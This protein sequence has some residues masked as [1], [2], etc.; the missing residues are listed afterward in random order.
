M[1]NTLQRI[2]NQKGFTLVELMIVV[3][4][5]GILAAIAIPAF[6]RSVKK[7]KTSEAEGTMRKVADGSK[8]YFQG[9]QKWSRPQTE[10]GE[11]PWHAGNPMQGTPTT[12]GLP[13]PWN[14]YTFP[15]GPAF[16]FN[17]AD[18]AADTG[19]GL[20]D[21]TKAPSGGSKQLGFAGSPTQPTEVML[22][23]AALNRVGVSFPDQYYFTYDYDSLGVAEGA[24]L[25]IRALAEFQTGGQCHT[26]QQILSIDPNTQEVIVGPPNTS[27][28]YE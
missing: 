12:Y 2:R 5:I 27:F 9:E 13:V 19:N 21:C 20:G 25:T 17:T 22:L 6:L 14:N 15:G 4:I 8:G 24:V 11:Q 16:Q 1:Q 26:I 28:E 23:N 7:S 10:G 3:A 18:P